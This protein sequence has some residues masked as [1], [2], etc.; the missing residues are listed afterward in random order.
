ME[1]II[2]FCFYLNKFLG[3]G[4]V[5]VVPLLLVI[6]ILNYSL[7][8]LGADFPRNLVPSSCKLSSVRIERV[9]NICLSTLLSVIFLASV[10]LASRTNLVLLCLSLIVASYASSNKCY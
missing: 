2:I 10:I 6:Y 7:L 4:G 9:I 5:T 1:K 8:L 3:V